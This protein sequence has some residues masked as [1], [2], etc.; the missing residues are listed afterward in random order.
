MRGVRDLTLEE[1]Y[2]DFGDH[3]N[4]KIWPFFLPEV[5][6]VL[7][8]GSLCGETSIVRL[9]TLYA[10]KH[11]WMRRFFPLTPGILNR[12]ILHD[13]TRRMNPKK[14]KY[15]FEDWL[16]RYFE[17]NESLRYDL[18][19]YIGPADIMLESTHVQSVCT[20]VDMLDLRDC[21][22][23][24]NES[25]GKTDIAKSVQSRGGVYLQQVSP[26]SSG[27]AYRIVCGALKGAIEGACPLGQIMRKEKSMQTGDRKPLKS[28]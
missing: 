21:V 3:T 13:V 5:C 27:D 1:I 23:L 19:S 17:E 24:I 12:Y 7:M 14:I 26:E 20:G 22:A 10:E 8:T 28:L 6:F 25:E 18:D 11:D 15:V 9:E 4:D 2:R 16:P